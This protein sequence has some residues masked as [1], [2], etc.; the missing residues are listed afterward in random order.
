MSI[1]VDNAPTADS[2]GLSALA[3]IEPLPSYLTVEVPTGESSNSDLVLPDF[4]STQGLSG[5]AFFIGGFS[6]FG[7]SINSVLAGLTSDISTGTEE[8][9]ESFSYALQLES[10]SAF[11]LTLEAT[12]GKDVS[13]EPPWVHG[14]SFQSAPEGLSSGFHIK[15]WL[16][17]LPPFCLL[18]TSPSPRD[19]G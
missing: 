11:D 19:R 6:D 9:D 16:P 8:V 14:I 4:N 15:T 12:Y 18:Y 10:D 1:N 7:R 2:S 5:V 13:S 17:G 3:L